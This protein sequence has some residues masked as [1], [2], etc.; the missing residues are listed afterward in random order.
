MY[1]HSEMLP[2]H[3]YPFFKKYDNFAGN[4]GNAWWKQREEF[5]SFNGQ[6]VRQEKIGELLKKYENLDVHQDPILEGFNIIHDK[7][8][9]KR[10]K[11]IPASENL[12]KLLK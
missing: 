11:N 6:N 7:V 8:G 1:T 4:Y 2:A 9:V 5:E 3:Y 12:I 10:R